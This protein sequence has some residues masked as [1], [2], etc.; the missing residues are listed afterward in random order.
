MNALARWVFWLAVGGLGAL[1][2]A[3]LERWAMQIPYYHPEALDDWAEVI[4]GV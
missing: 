3:G 2:S 4:A 1:R